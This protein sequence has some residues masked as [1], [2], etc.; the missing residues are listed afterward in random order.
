VDLVSNS[1]VLI[2]PAAEPVSLKIAKGFGLAA[3]LGNRRLAVADPAAVPA[4]K[5]ARRH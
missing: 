1:L 5:Y 3:A 2:A 4:G